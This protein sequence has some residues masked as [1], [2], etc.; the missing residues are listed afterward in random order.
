MSP[1]LFGEILEMFL[2]TLTAEGNYPIQDWENFQ[3]PIQMQL[4]ETRK[5][6]FQFFVSFTEYTSNFKHLQKKDDR[7][8]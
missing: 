3:L 4:S 7:H 6:F 5:I 2:N 8:S 1:V